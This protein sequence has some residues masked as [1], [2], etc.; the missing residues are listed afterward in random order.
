MAVNMSVPGETTA[1]NWPQPSEI[2][3]EPVVFSYDR[4]SDTL[5]IHFYGR[6]RDA[7]SNLA[8]D[9]W[10]VLVDPAT[11]AVVGL[12]IED[13]LSRAVVDVPPLIRILDLSELRG[14]TPAEVSRVRNRIMHGYREQTKRKPSRWLPPEKRKRA[15]LHRMLERRA[16]VAEPEL[17]A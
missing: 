10:Y 1:W 5:F 8:G 6:G 16:P 12:Q 3:I 4:V 15:L 7:V 14:I 11:S 9:Y 17:A 13:F 2:D